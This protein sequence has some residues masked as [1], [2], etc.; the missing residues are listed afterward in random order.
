[1][2]R[3]VASSAMLLMLA[4]AGC[5][6]EPLVPTIP[7]ATIIPSSTEATIAPTTPEVPESPLPW[8][9]GIE[10][11][12]KVPYES[13]RYVM[14]N[15]MEIRRTEIITNTDGAKVSRYIDTVSGFKDSMTEKKI[16][17]EIEMALNGLSDEVKDEAL[18]RSGNS[19]KKVISLQLSTNMLCSFTNVMF[20][21]YYA[22]AEYPEADGIYYVQ[23]FRSAGYDLN[24]GK[25]LELKDLFRKDF[26]YEKYLNDKILMYIIENNYDDPDSG[27]LSAPFK[28]MREDQS[29]SFDLNGVKVIFDEKNDEFMSLDYPL[30]I[31]IPLR[32]VGDNLAIFDRYKSEDSLFLKEGTRI[33][34]PNIVEYR[35]ES[36]FQDFG[37]TYAVSITNGRFHGIKDSSLLERLN[38][39][40]ASSLDAEGFIGR[41]KANENINPVGYYGSM[42]HDVQLI[43]NKGGYLSIVFMDLIYELGNENVSRLFVNIDLTTGKEMLLKDIFIDGFDYNGK[44]LSTAGLTKDAASVQEDEFY[45]DESGIYVNILQ[46]DVNLGVLNTWIPY[47]DL[48]YENIAIYNQ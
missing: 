26:N 7:S 32:E 36:V 21:E 43:M 24:T 9:P 8:K 28:G 39:L 44:I 48:G 14:S 23:K 15:G 35:P 38:G 18:T 46:N 19:E 6:K 41:A 12:E 47:E 20:M 27:F 25:K 45:F 2:K 34:I 17:D 11:L 30:S 1:M 40:A 13:R 10:T 42:N 33:L 16:N 3:I 5:S 37:A 31:V 29:F 4:L 22:Y